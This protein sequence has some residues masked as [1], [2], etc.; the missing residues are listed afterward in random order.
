MSDTKTNSEALLIRLREQLLLSQV[1]IMELE[2]A[3]DAL[4]QR[5]A[6]ERLLVSAAQ[7]LADG[8]LEKL[9]H[10]EKVHA[11]L[12]GQFQH[13]RHMQH[14]TNEALEETR[15]RLD[16]S[17]ADVA[18]KTARISELESQL[19]QKDSELGSLHAK[20]AGLDTKLG[21]AGQALDRAGAR[22]AE[23]DAVIAQLTAHAA[24]REERLSALAAERQAI[25]DSRSWRWS[26][27]VR[28]IERWLRR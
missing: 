21:E 7:S 5:L 8:A 22:I 26:A 4:A 14:V 16:S 19:N 9:A 2:D 24:T 3:R 11:G 17:K 10:L 6:D 18:G 15:A 28:A 25:V 23:L 20:V 1:R 27:P 12:E 13:M